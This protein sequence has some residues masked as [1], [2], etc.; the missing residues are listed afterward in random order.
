MKKGD[1][2]PFIPI[3]N[4]NLGGAR[5]LERRLR[6]ADKRGSGGRLCVGT[7]RSRCNSGLAGESILER[8]RGGKSIEA[9]LD[10]QRVQ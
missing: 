4:W 8:I 7:L 3:A 9:K 1:V 5:I 2:A 10:T 6:E